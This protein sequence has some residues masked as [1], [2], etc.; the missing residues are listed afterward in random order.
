M[1][2]L[3]DNQQLKNLC[4]QEGIAYL[5]LFGSYSRDEQTDSSDIDLL[6][7]FKQPVGYFKLVRVQ[8]DM[9]NL[10]NR[11]VDLVTENA[12]SKYIKPAVYKDL[13]VIYGSR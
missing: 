4:A 11:E 7:S 1:N 2:T 5:A 3:Q 13:K 10:L 12:L 9:K 6:V 8:N